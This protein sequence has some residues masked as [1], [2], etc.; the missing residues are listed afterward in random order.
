[1]AAAPLFCPVP[2]APRIEAPAFACQRC[3]E[4]CRGKGGVWLSLSEVPLASRFLGLEEPEFQERFL[5]RRPSRGG[6][7][8]FEVVTSGGRCALYRDGCLIHPVKPKACR[9]WPFFPRVLSGREG[10]LEAASHC[11]GLGAISYEDLLAFRKLRT[12]ERE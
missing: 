6:E 7:E 3:G 5:A 11:P 9:E 8:I 10:F 4:C 1:M 12:R 2:A